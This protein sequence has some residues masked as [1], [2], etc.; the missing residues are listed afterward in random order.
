[1]HLASNNWISRYP[2][3][4][5]L[6]W[7]TG[8][9]IAIAFALAPQV[10]PLIDLVQSFALA[11]TLGWQE[12]FADGF[13]R[14]QQYRPF[15]RLLVKLLYDVAGLNLWFYKSLVLIQFLIILTVLIRNLRPSGWH[16]STAALIA[17]CCI[18]GLPSTQILLNVLSPNHYSMV[19]LL[20][21]ATTALVMEPRMRGPFGWL[22][23]PSTLLGLLFLELGALVPAVLTALWLAR[24]P[25]IDRRGVTASWLA[26]VIYACFRL[27]LGNQTGALNYVE[28]NYGFSELSP[29]QYNDLF[30][31]A[32][33][34]FAIYNVAASALTVLF[35]EPRAGQYKFIES[36][37][38]RETP[39]WLWFHVV[40][41]T[42][43]TI[44]VASLVP[45][46]HKCSPRDFQLVALG[47][48]LV[49]GGS[50]L[51]FLYTR[52]R[53]SVLVGIGY[54]ILLYVSLSVLWETWGRHQWGKVCMVTVMVILAS[55]WTLR[56]CEMWLQLH[57][58]AWEIHAEWTDRYEN[59]I[60]PRF[61][62]LR[63]SAPGSAD[64]QLFLHQVHLLQ[65]LRAFALANPPENPRND[66][67]WTFVIFER[68]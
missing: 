49:T 10:W 31:Q 68:E 66:P 36:F 38:L 56:N 7:A 22:F 65:Y 4:V 42:I 16:R 47:L 21:L 20:L 29:A 6:L 58:E 15:Q 37:L 67:P 53:I 28:S 30:G 12:T 17:L 54:A 1:M 8:F 55:S 25:G 18:G 35:S 43:T 3:V 61:G 59:L 46:R 60:A 41:S 32:P 48:T 9:T 34:L 45:L 57:D 52:D 23:L 39:V 26:L 44:V 63:G 19:T 27:M 33:Y 24:A 5:P 14:G 11:E 62:P 13:G 2:T 51:G 64:L 40:S 50:A